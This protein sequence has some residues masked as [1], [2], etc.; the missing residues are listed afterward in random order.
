MHLA[1]IYHGA[2]GRRWGVIHS[3]TKQW[4]FPDR[5]GRKAAEDMARE[6]NHTLQPTGLIL[7]RVVH[8]GR[9]KAR[10]TTVK[11]GSNAEA[12]AIAAKQ[13]GVSTLRIKTYEL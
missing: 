4:S 7:Y 8:M 12:A 5:P 6:L 10:S 11:A 3:K 1:G 9:T 13:W 2:N